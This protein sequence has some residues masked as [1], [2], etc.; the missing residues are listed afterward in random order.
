MNEGGHFRHDRVNGL[1]VGVMVPEF[2]KELH[3][4][5]GSE[6]VLYPRREGFEGWELI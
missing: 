3:Q 4:V 2:K 1:L 5:T 6:V